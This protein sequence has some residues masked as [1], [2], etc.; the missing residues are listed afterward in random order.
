MK[1][2]FLVL[3]I[4][5]AATLSFAQSKTDLAGVWKATVKAGN[6]PT[7]PVYVMLNSDGTY[8]WGT[9]SSGNAL[10]RVWK[11]TWDLTDENEIKITSSDTPP[12]I[13]Y[14]APT[15]GNMIY[16]YRYYD[17]NGQKMKDRSTDMSQYLQKLGGN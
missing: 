7:T 6:K 5:F 13:K 1:R 8:L 9:D 3:L 2:T 15:G 11:G 12:T 14:Y 17:D 4:L 16:Q 10:D